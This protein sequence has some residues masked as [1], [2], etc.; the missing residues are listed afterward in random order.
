M[1]VSGFSSTDMRAGSGRFFLSYFRRLG[2]RRA[3][4][5]QDAFHGAEQGGSLS[6]N[7]RRGMDAEAELRV[8]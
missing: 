7:P 4:W 1:V 3:S 8:S 2:A 5:A 6:G